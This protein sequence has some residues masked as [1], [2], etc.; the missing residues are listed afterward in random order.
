LATAHAKARLSR[1]VEEKDAEAAIELLHFAIF[2]KVIEKSKKKRRR[3][4]G[5]EETDEE[6]EDKEE[7]EEQVEEEVIKS[8][9]R[10]ASSRKRRLPSVDENSKEMMV[11]EDE[12]AVPPPKQKAKAQ[13]VVILSEDRMKQFKK[14][15]MNEFRRIHAQTL[16][17]RDVRQAL[18]S[19]EKADRFTVDE[20]NFCLDELQKK[21]CIMVSDD[22]VFLI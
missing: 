4:D 3:E 18:C 1:N 10:G 17:L 8:L 6:G 11:D 5:E 13:S 20:V 12:K 19:S 7:E 15:L 2:K 14:L 9:Q 16:H 21:N 22:I